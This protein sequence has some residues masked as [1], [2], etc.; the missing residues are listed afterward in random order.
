[1]NATPT[2]EEADR[3][4]RDVE[5]RRQQ[6]IA[7]AGWPRWFWVASGVFVAAYGVLLDRHA[8]NSWGSLVPVVLAGLALVTRTRWGSAVIGRPISPPAT[9]VLPPWATGL[10]VVVLVLLVLAAGFWSVPHL[11]LAF[12]VVAGLLLAV[13]G[14]WWQNKVLTWR[15]RE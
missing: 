5:R 12:S 9:S 1:V 13:G 11:T 10:L 15:T 6:S 14:P 3:A 7:A 4:L 2:P 8:L